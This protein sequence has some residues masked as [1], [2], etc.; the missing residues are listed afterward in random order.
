[1]VDANPDG[2]ANT[3]DAAVITNTTSYLI[4]LGTVLSNSEVVIHHAENGTSHAN[5]FAVSGGS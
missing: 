2:T 1:M 4:V 3:S 5:I